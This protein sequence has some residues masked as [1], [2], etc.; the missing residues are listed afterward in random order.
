AALFA[1]VEATLISASNTTVGTP[2][3]YDAE[4]VL[5][6]SVLFASVSTIIN[7]LVLIEHLGALVPFAAMIG[8]EA[9]TMQTARTSFQNLL[10]RYGWHS[11]QWE[12]LE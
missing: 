6:Y 9:T 10:A 12:I 3:V 7:S 2:V 5:S 8:P 1:G 4:L 11:R